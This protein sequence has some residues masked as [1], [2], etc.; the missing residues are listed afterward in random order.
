MDAGDIYM[1]RPLSLQGSATE[2]LARAYG[3]IR[4]MIV[5]IVASKPTPKPQTGEPTFFRRRTPEQSEITTSLPSL[6]ALHDHIRMLDAPGY[7]NA[8]L[9][10]GRYTLR[11][12]DS[13]LSDGS[14]GARL[15]I[16]E[17]R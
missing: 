11:F 8:F 4:E 7:P 12:H 5:E 15:T 2:I 3:I 16:V 6:E 14:V 1:K 13:H 9:R 17:N 10:V